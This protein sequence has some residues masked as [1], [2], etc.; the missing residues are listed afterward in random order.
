MAKQIL[1]RMAVR[2][3]GITIVFALVAGAIANT[4][5]IWL[6]VYLEYPAPT[7][8]NWGSDRS[9]GPSHPGERR[10]IVDMTNMFF[11]TTVAT[12]DQAT[13]P[14]E[15]SDVFTDKLVSV[16][17]WSFAHTVQLTELQNT[18]SC[19]EEARGW[20]LRSLLWRAVSP[21]D[22]SGSIQWEGA[23][24]V[25]NY[26]GNTNQRKIIPYKII[27]MG[28]LVDSALYALVFWV[29]MKCYCSLHTIRKRRRLIRNQCP[30][31]AYP[32]GTSLRCSECGQELLSMVE[33]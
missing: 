33:R 17:S 13:Y 4:M 18:P 3:L 10:W 6:T 14:V 12:R 20:P 25:G 24:V 21:G 15:V 28:F 5:V 2:K 9:F 16:P 31:C 26:S 22:G 8:E 19:L 7:R 30:H 1:I 29:A 32:I 11:R 23:F 27:P